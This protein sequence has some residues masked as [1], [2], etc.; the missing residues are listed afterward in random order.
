M[1]KDTIHKAITEADK[2]NIKKKFEAWLRK[3]KSKILSGKLSRTAFGK[4]LYKTADGWDERFASGVTQFLEGKKKTFSLASMSYK[5]ARKERQKIPKQ[6]LGWLDNQERLFLKNP[7]MGLPPGTREAF[8]KHIKTGARLK[9]EWTSKLAKELGI[10]LHKEHM[11]SLARLGADD[12][13]AQFPGS[14]LKNMSQGKRDSFRK[15]SAF[16]KDLVNTDVRSNQAGM[17][18]IPENWQASASRFGAT[19]RQAYLDLVQEGAEL[20]LSKPKELQKI[21]TKKVGD[22][23]GYSASGTVLTESDKLTLQAAA[24]KGLKNQL[25]TTDAVIA[26][27]QAYDDLKKY[28][29][30]IPDESTDVR[31]GVVAAE[32]AAKVAKAQKLGD[33]TRKFTDLE[34]VPVDSGHYKKTVL[35]RV[36]PEI[37]KWQQFARGT[38]RLRQA[39]IVGRIVSHTPRVLATPVVGGE[40]M[41]ALGSYAKTGD[42]V[43]LKDFGLATAKDVAYGAGFATAAKVVAQKQ[44]TRGL[45]KKTLLR[46]ALG[47]VSGPAG[48]V[49][50]GYTA[51]DAAN[52]FTEAYT[53]TS[54][55]QRIGNLFINRPDDSINR[56]ALGQL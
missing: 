18:D 21:L 37:P 35:P 9:D 49:M 14:A 54:I 31:K 10:D 48:W 40:Q 29:F 26:K 24:E 13:I 44:L 39:N 25:D 7:K 34:N 5:I 15:L 42:A 8:I 6:L 19:R 38:R 50:L 23:G 46:G 11:Y 52:Q 36:E 12:P 56:V 43:H 51:Y 33:T 2:V 45:L 22:A 55:N 28:G 53:G 17:M 4:I 41:H 32:E 3:N 1:A 16:I 47:A 20:D 27:R 30:E